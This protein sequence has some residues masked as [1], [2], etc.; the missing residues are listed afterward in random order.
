M[1]GL[2]AKTV[3]LCQGPSRRQC[4]QVGGLSAVGLTLPELLG[5]R[6]LARAGTQAK[7][8]KSRYY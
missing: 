7:Q 4:L 3:R 8:N 2:K 1:L 6:V 5:R